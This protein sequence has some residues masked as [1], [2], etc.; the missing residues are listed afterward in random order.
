VER[1][2]ESLF[3]RDLDPLP[4]RRVVLR[5]EEIEGFQ[6]V[7]V[8]PF[9][10]VLGWLAWAFVLGWALRAGNPLVFLLSLPWFLGPSRLFQF[11]CLDC[12]ATGWYG[13]LD[14]HAC[15]GVVA[16]REVGSMGRWP[17]DPRLQMR[18]WFFTLALGGLVYL[19]LLR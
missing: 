12:G 8:N 6:R 16:R 15:A 2:R 11:H 3:D 13:R 14:R 9:L 5:A 18:L 1:D 10:A 19:I 17:L 7:V 4:P